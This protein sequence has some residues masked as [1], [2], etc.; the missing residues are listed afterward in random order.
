MSVYVGEIKALSSLFFL[1]SVLSLHPYTGVTTQT[2]VALQSLQF[3]A[4]V[5]DSIFL[6]MIRNIFLASINETCLD[7]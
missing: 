5:V 6:I 3:S 7:V 2:I 4:T 1:S